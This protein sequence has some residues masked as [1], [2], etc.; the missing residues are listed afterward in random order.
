MLVMKFGG[1]SVG[2]AE[3]IQGA[4][5]IV[6]DRLDKK[7]VVIVSA[8]A[9][10]T[11]ALIEIAKEASIEAR[12]NMLEVVRD[13]HKKI[14]SGL[15]LEMD[16]LDA[17]F[18]EL[19]KLA[20]SK[21]KLDKKLQ[22][23]FVSFGERMCAPMVA[24]ALRKIGVEA[25][26]FPAWEIGMIT[27][28]DFGDAEPLPIS[29]GVLKKKIEAAAA[30]V[31]PSPERRTD[32][33]ETN[34]TVPV[35]TGYIG[36]TKKG[37]ITTLGRG[38]SD[39]TAAVIGSALKAEAIQIWKEVDGIMTTDPRLVP[40]ARVVSELAF[41]E[42]S[43]LAYFGAKVLHP[44][45][46][47]PAMKAGVPVQVL[48]TFNPAG[49]GTT[50]VS[51]FSERRGKSHSVEALTFKKGVIAIHVNS[52]EFFDGSGLM[53]QLFKILEKLDVSVDV[54]TTSVA[55]VSVTITDADAVPS[56]TKALSKLGTVTVDA[57]KAIVC[58]VGGSVNAAGVAGRMFTALGESQ[59]KVEMISQAAGG[60][61]LTFVVDEADAETAL[62]VLHKEHIG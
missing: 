25:K 57:N 16:L 41:E 56:L 59:I 4:A 26:S 35:I 23:H 9:G 21:K 32:L 43:E 55:G 5:A 37:E 24:G 12:Q 40:E 51:S 62:K 17:E 49:E 44:R 53:A 52:P 28:E 39:Y 10:M 11:N 60:I 13:T 19:E 15:G 48:N 18:A 34:Y 6:K 29:F 2:S 27:D 20:K 14:L 22:D 45:T 7:P 42:A 58:V 8:V 30:K 61:S 47:L 36:K 31:G 38:G 3:R 46:I 1:T 54:V 33:R 50:I